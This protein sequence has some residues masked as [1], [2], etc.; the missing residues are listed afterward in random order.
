M[1]RHIGK[2]ARHEIVKILSRVKGFHLKTPKLLFIYTQFQ[3]KKS[4]WKDCI[5][6]PPES[7]LGLALQTHFLLACVYSSL[8]VF[9][10]TRETS[11]FSLKHV[12]ALS[13]PS[14]LPK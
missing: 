13:L 8:L 3:G 2:S 10:S 1:K 4:I 12:L 6:A 5:K 7:Q 14:H 11:V 9:F